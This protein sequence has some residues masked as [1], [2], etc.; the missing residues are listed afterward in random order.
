MPTYDIPQT[1]LRVIRYV[2]PV[3]DYIYQS[4]PRCASSLGRFDARVSGWLQMDVGNWTCPRT[5]PYEP[6]LAIPMEV[7]N[8]D[9]GWADC[10]GG[11]YGVYD[12]PIALTPVSAIAKPTMPGEDSGKTS[13]AVPASTPKPT[14]A[15]STSPVKPS[16]SPAPTALGEAQSSGLAGSHIIEASASKL[17]DSGQTGEQQLSLE[18]QQSD[19]RA[20]IGSAAQPIRIPPG[21]SDAVSHEPSQHDTVLQGGPPQQQTA[22]T[23]SEPKLDALSILLA[24]QSSVP[25]PAH[26][27]EHA[28]PVQ[29]AHATSQKSELAEPSDP[30]ADP[31]PFSVPDSGV[32]T[33][34]GVGSVTVQQVGSSI[35][36]Q[37]D[38][39]TVTLAQN[40]RATIAGHLFSP[41][42]DGGAVIVD[43]SITHLLPSSA[44]GQTAFATIVANGET[45]TALKQGSNVVLAVAGNTEAQTLEL[46]DAVEIGPQTANVASDGKE[47]VVGSSTIVIPANT[48]NGNGGASEATGA[49]S[50]TTVLQD[51]TELIASAAE[52]AVI[53]QQGTYAVTLAAGKETILDGNTMS[54][55]R[56]GGALIVNQSETI[57]VPTG[58][59]D[60]S[61]TTAS[62]ASGDRNTG[63]VGETAGS[64]STSQSI[65]ASS[66]AGVRV[67][68]YAMQRLLAVS[69][70]F[71]SIALLR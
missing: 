56:S 2:S 19:A 25:A 18:S 69:C 35:I 47:L 20:H 6:I 49:G 1:L 43:H 26:D 57:L 70:V 53:I 33:V 51:G 44:L 14:A 39:S 16:A 38:E 10:V 52:S 29:T 42:P 67:A 22:A 13:P 31:G 9:P 48:V 59:S 4:Q 46:G 66:N 36:V 24:A 40:S 37:Q 68:R 61:P 27:Q 11:I 28:D 7:R 32:L 5:A 8:L 64:G 55:M 34:A 30:S 58:P 50:T 62:R 21:D 45:I 41:A 15:A 3:P 12:P 63:I 54:A 65:P 71:T 60:G 17:T 23:T